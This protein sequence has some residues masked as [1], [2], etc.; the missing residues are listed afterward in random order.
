MHNGLVLLLTFFFHGTIWPDTQQI[1]GEQ[2]IVYEANIS[3]NGPEYD[4]AM[5]PQ[6]FLCTFHN[7]FLDWKKSCFSD[8]I[9]LLVIDLSVY[10][11]W[12]HKV[13]GHSQMVVD[14]FLEM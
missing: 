5:T 4:A 7:L 14:A 1:F 9:V 12:L 6:A 2:S 13:Y 3:V 11:R 8:F 10:M